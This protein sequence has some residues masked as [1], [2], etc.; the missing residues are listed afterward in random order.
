MLLRAL[1]HRALSLSPRALVRPSPTRLAWRALTTFSGPRSPPML[2][3]TI[4]EM[5]EA[6]AREHPNQT[7]LVAVEED[8]R[9]T[10]HEV[11]A[12]V[13]AM[14]HALRWMGLEKG[15]RFGAWLPNTGDYYLV[16]MAC[17]KIGVVL[18]NVNPAYRAHEF[19]FAMN[20]VQCKAILITPTVHGTDYIQVLDSILPELLSETSP[21]LHNEHVQP[22]SLQALPHLKYIL[23]D[24]RDKTY[25]GMVALH[26]LIAHAESRAA[27]PTPEIAPDDV[28][29]IQFTSG[30]TGTPKGA[31]LTH[32]NLLN[33][34][35]FAGQRCGYSTKDRVCIPVPL[36]H[37]FGVVLGNLAC[38]AHASTAV[39]PSKQ[40]NEVAALNAVESEGC[41]SLY[42]VPTM[43]IRMLN[44]PTFHL[45]RVKT[46]RT[47][48]MAGAPCPIEI[49]QEVLTFAPEMTIGYGMTETSPL[50][51]QTRG[52][53][54]LD[55]RVA[56][57][58]ALLPFVDAKVVDVEDSSKELGPNQ[59]GELMVKGYHIMQ[60][61]W[62]QPKETAKS[63]EDGWMHTGDIVAMDERGY[64]RIVGRSK[65]VIIRGGENIYPREI[66]EVLFAH[67]SV[68]NASVIGVPDKVYGEQV[69][70]WVHLQDES[71]SV[72]DV[73]AALRAHLAAELA[74]FKVP[75][76]FLFKS[77][78]PTTITGKVQ[79]F[80][81]RDVTIAELGLPKTV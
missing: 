47:G 53:D 61:Y 78:F 71:T 19:E 5:L 52:D 28:I 77:E 34:G 58:G 66:E 75:K 27:P 9:W 68:A 73:E 26:D 80:M 44:S 21:L 67:P 29:N 74:H 62:D 10:Y 39:Y 50:S 37:C 63:I 40:F 45:D 36:Y 38:L 16:Q 1:R 76:Y 2:E 31:A 64:C 60:G 55:D 49:M 7:A 3:C 57:V 11:N 72:V 56:T 6:A 18:V 25:P 20:L 42:G 51:F 54:A 4:G 22:L 13:D 48:I 81:M 43:F 65:D 69:C 70:A 12:K 23:H 46:L 8:I 15:D 35:Y 30:T 33:N 32:R 79:K 17:A 14:A 41:T 59:A 24:A